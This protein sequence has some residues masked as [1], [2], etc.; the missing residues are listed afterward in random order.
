MCGPVHFQ[1]HSLWVRKRICAKISFN[2]WYCGWNIQQH[3]WHICALQSS[4]P[5]VIFLYTLFLRSLIRWYIS[6]A[7]IIMPEYWWGKIPFYR[8]FNHNIHIYQMNMRRVNS[9]AY[10][11]LGNTYSIQ[12]RL[13]WRSG[14]TL[15]R[16]S[17]VTDLLK[18]CL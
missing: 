1:C 8:R 15:S 18:S 17:R 3:I 11:L 5:R 4:L 16:S 6:V 13:R 2:C 10:K 12:Q 14:S 7:T 9:G